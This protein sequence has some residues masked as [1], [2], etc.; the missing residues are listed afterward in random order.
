MYEIASWFDY[1]KKFCH[2]D[3]YQLKNDFGYLHKRQRKKI[4]KL[5]FV[6][7]KDEQAEEKLYFQKLLLFLPWRDEETIKGNFA[8]YKSAFESLLENTDKINL[9]ILHNF[10]IQKQKTLDA[11][12]AIRKIQVEKNEP[13]KDDSLPQKFYNE[14]SLG[15]ID[16]KIQNINEELLKNKINKLNCEQREIFEKIM[17]HIESKQVKGLKIFCSGVGGML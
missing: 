2:F 6:N 16:F 8:T 12:E 1:K 17:Y 14:K 3:C 9:S 10:N 15:I 5:P 7:Y 13:L 11:I 4:L